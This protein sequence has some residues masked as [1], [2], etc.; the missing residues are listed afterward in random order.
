[1]ARRI[2]PCERPRVTVMIAVAVLAVLVAS[3]MVVIKIKEPVFK[4]GL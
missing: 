4:L 1:V 3:V 2:I